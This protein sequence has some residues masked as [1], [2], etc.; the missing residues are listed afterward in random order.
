MDWFEKFEWTSVSWVVSNFPIK[1]KAGH[2]TMTDRALLLSCMVHES[3]I[4]KWMHQMNWFEKFEWIHQMNWFE[5]FEWIHQMKYSKNWNEQVALYCIIK[6]KWIDLKNSNEQV[7]LY[8]RWIDSNKW[9]LVC[10]RGG[11]GREEGE[12]RV[13]L[14]KTSDELIRK[15]CIN[16]WLC[17]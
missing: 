13:D 6:I 16:K 7:A 8:I 17:K 5:K 1:A 11:G 10:S 2:H 12:R 9:L 4:Y 3:K 15:N 14:M